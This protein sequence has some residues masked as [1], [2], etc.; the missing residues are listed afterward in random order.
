VLLAEREC[1]T[2]APATQFQRL[3]RHATSA[4]AG[5]AA[6]MS[7]R[8]ARARRCARGKMLMHGLAARE[9]QMMV[10]MTIFQRA[11]GDSCVVC[12]LDSM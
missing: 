3:Q 2:L 7:C 4:G 11:F 5:G 10:Y 1:V 6:E 8:V 12:L 9:A